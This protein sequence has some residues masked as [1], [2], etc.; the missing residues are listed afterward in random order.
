[1]KKKIFKEKGDNTGKDMINKIFG[2]KRAVCSC[3]FLALL[4]M[5]IIP[6]L[7]MN[8]NTTIKIVA[9]YIY[10]GGCVVFLGYFGYRFIKYKKTN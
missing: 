3:F 9:A 2:T 10:I 5:Y 8:R 4:I 7:F 1:M 6:L